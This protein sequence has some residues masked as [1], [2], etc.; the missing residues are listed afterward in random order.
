MIICLKQRR[1]IYSLSLF[2]S[3][4][5]RVFVCL[6]VFIFSCYSIETVISFNDG[7]FYFLVSFH[8]APKQRALRWLKC[9]V[10]WTMLWLR[11]KSNVLC[12]VCL[13]RTFTPVNVN[14]FPISWDNV[15][16]CDCCRWTEEMSAFLFKIRLYYV[17]FP[18]TCKLIPVSTPDRGTS[19]WMWRSSLLTRLVKCSRLC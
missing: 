7:C 12:P 17:Y 14:G 8:T 3:L 15:H 10:T 6:R 9:V 5:K 18:D 13:W 1:W 16:L 4:W 19:R 2:G 11:L